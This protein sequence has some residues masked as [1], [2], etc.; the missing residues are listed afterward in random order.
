MSII[1]ARRVPNPLGGAESCGVNQQWDPNARFG[2]IVGQCTPKGSA[3]TPAPSGFLDSLTAGLKVLMPTPV[4]AAP[5][6]APAAPSSGMSQTTMIAI[7]LG[8]VG[9]IAIILATRK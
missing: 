6:Y 5:V 8:A 9:L 1:Y 4:P 7:G 2:S 3:M